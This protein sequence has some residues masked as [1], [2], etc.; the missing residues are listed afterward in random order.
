MTRHVL[1]AHLGPDD[2]YVPEAAADEA[3]TRFD[4]VTGQRSLGRGIGPALRALRDLGV[5]PTETGVDL[6]VVAAHV[7][8]A[9]TRLS[10]VATSQDG[11]TREIGL[12]VPV[13]EPERWSAAAPILERM[14]RF[15]TGDHWR[16]R[17]RPRPAGFENLSPAYLPGFEIADFDGIALFS[18]G[19]DSLIGAIDTLVAGERPL[20]VSHAGEGAVSG[21]QRDLFD[22][23]NERLPG[24]RRLNRNL[25]R[26]RFALT[27]P[28]NLVR[29]VPGEDSTRG[30][31]FLFLAIGAMAGSGLRRPFDLRVPENGLIA[32]N[33]PLDPTRLGSN[34]TRTTHPYY[35][36]RWNELLIAI[37]IEGTVVNRYWDQT[38]GEMVAGCRVSA[39]LRDLTPLSVSC[40]HPSQGRYARDRRR[41]CGTCVPCLIRR[42]AVEGAW[43]RG[44]DPTGYRCDDLAERPLDATR[45]EGRQVRGFQYA[46]GRLAA[47]PDLA[48]ILIHK[49]GPLKEDARNLDRLAGVYGR[50]MVEVGR[51][52][53]GVET[54]SPAMPELP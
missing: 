2:S 14:L 17:F 26:L 10:R 50:G 45:S 21:P 53:Q 5:R 29:G 7:H 31:S 43:G 34:S 1:A 35:L 9:D 28:R 47:S 25:P 48:R 12:V 52:L 6:I 4:L 27:F 49:P 37:G 42:A 16:I 24:D 18:G 23:L 15:L 46:I 36:R 30:R 44:N 19:L 41:H 39:V 3:V 13:S 51:L 38:K 40:A 11:W 33:V 54:F 20:F 22:K 8:A 32:L